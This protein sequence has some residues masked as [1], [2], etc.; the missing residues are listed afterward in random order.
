MNGSYFI[1]SSCTNICIKKKEIKANDFLKL[2]DDLP[3]EI[4]VFLKL[5]YF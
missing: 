3:S 1:I 5:K 2:R 4:I